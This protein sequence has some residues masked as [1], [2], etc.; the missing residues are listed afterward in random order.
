MIASYL[1]T[2]A[3]LTVADALAMC[4]VSAGLGAALVVV[5]LIL[6]IKLNLWLEDRQAEEDR[7]AGRTILHRI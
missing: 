3:P 2:P 5:V 4:V 6:W 7:I 1:N